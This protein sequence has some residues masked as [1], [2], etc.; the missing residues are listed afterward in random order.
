MEDVLGVTE[1]LS[2]EICNRIF[3][4]CLTEGEGLAQT[5]KVLFEK[6]PESK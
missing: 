2:D 6:K 5:F 4:K 1:T 3:L